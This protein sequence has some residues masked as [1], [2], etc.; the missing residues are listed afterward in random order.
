MDGLNNLITSIKRLTWYE[1]IMA[2]V[3]IAIA[4]YVM[5]SSFLDPS[6]SDNPTWLTVVNFISAVAGVFC[7]FLTA[8]VSISN[9][10]FSIVNTLSYMVYLFYWNIMGTFMLEACVY[11]PLAIGSWVMWVRHR[12]D[13][14]RV[15]TKAKRMSYPVMGLCAVAVILSGLVYNSI[16][17]GIGDPVAMLDAYTVAIGIVAIV[18]EL[19]RYREQYILW[20]ITDVIAVAMFIVHFDPV[21]LTKKAIYLIMAFVG[22]YNWYRLSKAHNPE[23]E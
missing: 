9:F 5:I 4:G 17:S 21:Y 16:L 2:A 1:W 3:M 8:K 14:D 18:L 23:N 12:D 19:L 15:L 6:S 11:L 20:L 13:R 22:L 7:I 10:V